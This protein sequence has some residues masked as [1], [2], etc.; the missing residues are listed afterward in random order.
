[1]HVADFGTSWLSAY[2]LNQVH[3]TPHK[4]RC[5]IWAWCMGCF[6]FFGSSLVL[7][8]NRHRCF[9]AIVSRGLIKYRRR[10]EFMWCQQDE[11]STSQ[12]TYTCV[13]G[14]VIY[15]EYLHA[16]AL[17]N[18]SFLVE[19]LWFLHDQSVFLGGNSSHVRIIS[20]IEL[21][22]SHEVVPSVLSA[23]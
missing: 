9:P 12:R 19:Y 11:L 15:V 7:S 21:S 23:V 2:L 1:M 22:F 20:S 3:V 16:F 10:C 5:P 14:H 8:S 6:N 4:E 18:M 13:S 17:E